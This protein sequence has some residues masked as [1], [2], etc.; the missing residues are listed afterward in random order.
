MTAPSKPVMPEPPE[1]SINLVYQHLGSAKTQDAYWTSW[2]DG[3]AINIPSYS[4]QMLC[5]AYARLYCASLEATIDKL[6]AQL[7]ETVHSWGEKCDEQ[8]RTITCLMAG[9]P[10]DGTTPVIR[11]I[12]GLEATIAT[13]KGEML[14]DEIVAPTNG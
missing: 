14:R 7:A 2:K 3:I 13:L 1:L 11:R 9:M 6:H 10:E 8:R 4:L 5:Q 12:A